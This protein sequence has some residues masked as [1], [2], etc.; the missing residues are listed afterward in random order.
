MAQKTSFKYPLNNKT[1]FTGGSRCGVADR[2]P[3]A[4]GGDVGLLPETGG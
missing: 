1:L 2:V 3:L 4:A